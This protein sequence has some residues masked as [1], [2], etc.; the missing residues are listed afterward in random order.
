M[1]FFIG[2]HHHGNLRPTKIKIIHLESLPFNIQLGKIYIVR[3][4]KWEFHC[5]W[6]LALRHYYCIC[7]REWWSTWKSL[8]NRAPWSWALLEKPPVVQLFKN[9]PTFYR[10]HGLITVLTRALHWFLSWIQ[11]CPRPCVTFCNKLICEMLFPAQP[12]SWR[13]NP[14]WPSMTAY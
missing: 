10:N 2:S 14:C 11:P 3:N 7:L 13:T 6:G 4:I 5:C 1:V 9:F 12:L 8:L